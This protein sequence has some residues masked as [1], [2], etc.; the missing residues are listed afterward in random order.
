MFSILH[1]YQWCYSGWL[2][3]TNIQSN[4][5]WLVNF[6]ISTLILHTLILFGFWNLFINKTHLRTH[7]CHVTNSTTGIYCSTPPSTELSK[8]TSMCSCFN[9]QI[10]SHLCL[11]YLGFQVKFSNANFPIKWYQATWNENNHQVLL[12]LLLLE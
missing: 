9:H 10:S 8:H 12:S 6:S 11:V 4:L 1:I 7:R 5:I 2:Y 3:T